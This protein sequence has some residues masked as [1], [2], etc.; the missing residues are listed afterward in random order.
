MELQ[1][2][3]KLVEQESSNCLRLPLDVMHF[4]LEDIREKQNITTI[5]KEMMLSCL[6]DEEKNRFQGLKFKLVKKCN[7]TGKGTLQNPYHIQTNFGEGKFFNFYEYFKKGKIPSVFRKYDCHT[8]CF[9][10]AVRSN[11]NCKILSGI[12]FRNFSFLHS[13]LLIDDYILDFNYDLVMSKDLYVNLFNFEILNVVESEDIKKYVHMFYGGSH[14][15]K[16]NKITYGDVNY[17]FYELIDILNDEKS[18]NLWMLF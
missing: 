17:C 8:N 7:L 11:K 2:F 1:E 4:S 15:F 16:E 14:F 3:R 10:F 6:V 9:E 5:I 12:C 13:V 18:F